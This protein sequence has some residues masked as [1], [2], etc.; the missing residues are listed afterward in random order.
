MVKKILNLFYRE[1][2]GLHKAALIFSRF[3][4]CFGGFRHLKRQ[5]AGRKLRCRE[6][7]DV[8]YA[9]FKIPILFT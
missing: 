9:A 4:H 5:I 3:V 1:Y 8:Y 2:G 7:L 6:S